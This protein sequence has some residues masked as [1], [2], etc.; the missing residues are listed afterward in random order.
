MWY[1]LVLGLLAAQL[2]LLLLLHVPPAKR[3]GP[4]AAGLAHD[5]AASGEGLYIETVLA[6]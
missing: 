4:L 1:Y 5:L 2:L 6:A 3:S